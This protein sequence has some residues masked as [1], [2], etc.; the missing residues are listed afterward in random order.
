MNQVDG[1]P[2]IRLGKPGGG[3]SL[4][5]VPLPAGVGPGGWLPLCT[6]AATGEGDGREGNVPGGSSGV[7]V[8][9]T[10]HPV[11]AHTPLGLSV[12]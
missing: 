5:W 9:Q 2:A 10:A 4:W 8:L 6:R 7:L 1:D 3:G 11:M 12:S